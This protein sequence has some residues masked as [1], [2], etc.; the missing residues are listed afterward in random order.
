MG[1][2]AWWGLVGAS[3]GQL[4]FKF[5][6]NTESGHD[7]LSALASIDNISFY[8]WYWSGH[9]GGWYNGELDLANVPNVGSLME[10]PSVWIALVFESDESTN[11]PEGAYV[12]NIFL[13]R[14]VLATTSQSSTAEENTAG[15]PQFEDPAGI[16]A[17]AMYR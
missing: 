1:P 6:L 13:R 12:D 2:L 16:P 17:K 4:S 7:R 14:Y 8:G 11:Y 10:Q 3:G 9:P 15:S 5:W